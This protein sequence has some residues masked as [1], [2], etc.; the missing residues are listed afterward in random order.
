[1]KYIIWLLSICTIIISWCQIQKTTEWANTT[2]ERNNN[3]FSWTTIIYTTWTRIYN[4]IWLSNDNKDD[5]ELFTKLESQWENC[6]NRAYGIWGWRNGCENITWYTHTYTLPNLWIIINAYSKALPD[7]TNNPGIFNSFIKQ[8]FSLASN[9]I[10]T[11]AFYI[12][13][14]DLEQGLSTWA[15]DIVWKSPDTI[16]FEG[17]KYNKDINSI[18]ENNIIYRSKNDNNYMVLQYIF[19]NGKP[20]Y[21]TTWSNGL[22]CTPAP[23]ELDIHDIKYF[24]K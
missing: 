4:E 11:S 17:K 21:Y 15:W 13:Y 24:M 20:Y 23:C 10:Y 5:I 7:T 12:E 14:H 6:K 9:K 16:E 19:Q 1:M 22:W 18:S 3:W 2:I 8:P